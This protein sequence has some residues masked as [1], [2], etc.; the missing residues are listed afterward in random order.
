MKRR[1]RH[2]ALLGVLAAS[3][4][5]AQSPTTPA[6]PTRILV[7]YGTAV[8]SPSATVFLER[9]RTTIRSALPPPVEVYEE[10]LD[11]D[12]FPGPLHEVQ[13]ARNFSDK[14][15]D[16]P[17]DVVVAVG[18]Q[19]LQFSL[20]RVRGIM[21][22]VP[23]VFGLTYAHSV[24]VAQLPP[25]FTGRTIS[26][27]LGATLAMAR[28]L[29]PDADSAVVIAGSSPIDSAAMDDALADAASQRGSIRIV[30]W[31]GFPYDSLLGA[32]NRLSPRS[33]VFFAHFRR[34]GHG[35][36]MVPVYVVPEIARAS[37]APVYSFTDN[38]M[39]TGI[40]GGAMWSHND[41]AAQ[42][43]LLAVRV[44]RR[45]P[46]EAIPAV[47]AARLKFMADWRALRRWNLDENRLVF[48]TEV[49]FRTPTL[50]ERD[51][52]T[53]LAALGVMAAES[54]LIGLLLLERRKRIRA[55]QALADQATY[56]RTIAELMADAARHAPEDTPRALEDAIA[57]LGRYA[58]ADEVVLAECSGSLSRPAT[59]LQWTRP[60]ANGVHPS[61]GDNSG[62]TSHAARL[63]LP[64]VV[65]GETVGVLTLRRAGSA[66]RWPPQLAERLGAAADIV[67]GGIERSRAAL[68]AEEAGRQVAHMGRVA[69]IG[70]LASSISHELR[71][72]LAAIRINADAGA[73]LLARQ[74]PD[75]AEARQ[76]LEE[77]VADDAR[78]CEVVEHI[79]ALLRKES[80][81]TTEVNLNA[82]CREAADLIL[83]DARSRGIRLDLSLDPG[84]PPVSGHPIE[85]Q[86]V[87]LNLLLNAL[88]AVVTSAGERRIDVGTTVV[89]A[90]VEL[91]VRDSGPGLSPEG[92]EHL[93]ESF[94]STKAHGLGLG[95]VIVRSIVERHGG[96]IQAGNGETGGAIFRVRLPMLDRPLG[97]VR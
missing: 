97:R 7:L 68:R 22:G 44:L 88:D 29:Q 91:V 58:D 67:A 42:I 2:A 75:V 50:W 84:L 59:R 51:R 28:R 12:R 92:R 35:R 27:G 81:A 23:V 15:H 39:G 30:P 95:L 52:G 56:E 78:A 33:I 34:D 1:V 18:A 53:I 70:E 71:Q 65:A 47:E 93:F 86:Q 32:L 37:R 11:F 60:H 69:M 9:F 63:E 64:L 96:R 46:G 8:E 85:L 40:V 14:Y 45:A 73:L 3:A 82:I 16:A 57:R 17:P 20:D 26:L 83:R 4:L 61:N 66:E 31:Q 77:I 24:K 13:L 87:V 36:T 55:Q 5:H 79:R 41:E 10:F 94:F 48:D 54:L 74:P 38:L 62:D 19:A 49:L 72:P 6:R 21:P 89:D 90:G 80:S 25:N 43:A 76:V